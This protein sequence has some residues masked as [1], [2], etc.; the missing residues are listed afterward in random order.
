MA[1]TFLTNSLYKSLLTTSFF[2]TSVS[3][4]KSVGLTS[5]EAKAEIEIRPV[6]AES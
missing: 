4:L 6:T 1:I 3:L 5:N 2:T